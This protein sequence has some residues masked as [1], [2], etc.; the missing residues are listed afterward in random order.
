MDDPSLMRGFDRTRHLSGDVDDAADRNGPVCKDRREGLPIHELQHEPDLAIVL[1]EP[2]NCGDV[3]VVE[4]RQQMRFT[5]EPGDPGAAGRE[6]RADHLDRDRPP[7]PCVQRAV[8][9]THA[10]F[11]DLLDNPIVADRFA[12]HACIGAADNTLQ[13]TSFSEY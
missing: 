12:D 2:V 6:F 8:D 9:D 3:R 1:F 13:G 5:L 10:A 4:C 7:E 11:P